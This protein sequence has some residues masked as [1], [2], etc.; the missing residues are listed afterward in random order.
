M[1]DPIR[2]SMQGMDELVKQ[3]EGLSKAAAERALRRAVFTGAQPVVNEARN[4]A[5]KNSSTLMR[6][7]HAEVDA[8]AGNVR[9]KIGPGSEVPYAAIQEFGGE[10]KAKNGKYLAIPL[11]KKAKT[12][13]PRDFPGKL[14]PRMKGDGGVLVDE[15]GTAQYALKRSVTIPA[16]PYLRPA[17]DAKIEEARADMADTLR[18]QI[19]KAV[20]K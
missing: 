10:I 2:T 4:L 15:D 16:H 13:K 14:S 18:E 19:M 1:S 12:Y 8:E 20:N 17:Y 3:L 7:I 6:S 5:P 9:A 11:T